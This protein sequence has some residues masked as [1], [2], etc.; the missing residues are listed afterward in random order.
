[1]EEYT[2]EEIEKEISVLA[3][4]FAI[5]RLVDPVRCQILNIRKENGRP[6]LSQ[7]D[8]CYDVWQYS[9]QCTN[10]T[11]AR[12]LQEK[13]KQTKCEL[14]EE[15]PFFV[16]ARPLL[17]DGTPLVLE[18]VQPVSYTDAGNNGPVRELT[19]LIRSLNQ[20][21]LLDSETHAF[22]QEYLN[23]HLPNI[24]AETSG[25]PANAAL[26]RLVSYQKIQTDFGPVAASGAICQ[27]YELLKTTFTVSGEAPMLV[28]FNE[29]TFMVIDRNHRPDAFFKLLQTLKKPSGPDHLLF[30]SRQLPFELKAASACIEK[31]Q[32]PD[33][34]SLIS[35]L[36]K[37]LAD[38]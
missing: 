3:K 23:E 25:Q 16:T 22:S 33:S 14:C 8:T 11:S 5:V 15:K 31:E 34:T 35:V 7:G 37:R 27:L 38:S 12:A 10:C 26:V 36:L 13:T 28:R 4:S 9:S 21:V 6:V 17:V 1:M 29:N 30:Q 2:C 20:N 32:I 19:E 24:F 18:I